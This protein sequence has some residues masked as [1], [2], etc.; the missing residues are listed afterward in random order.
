MNKTIKESCPNCKNPDKD[1]PPMEDGSCGVCGGTGE[2]EWREVGR[3]VTQPTIT[4]SEEKKD[5]II[6][7][8][9]GFTVGVQVCTFISLI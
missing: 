6:W 9:L 5:R 3:I 8:L 4:M 1:I 2:I 7:F